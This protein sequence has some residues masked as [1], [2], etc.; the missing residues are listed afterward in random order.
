M[1]CE[2][3]VSYKSADSQN[4]NAKKASFLLISAQKAR[5]FANFC[6]FLAIFALPI[7]T[8]AHLSAQKPP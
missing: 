4:A 2:C 8:L 3:F 1:N 6:E 5:I 7:L